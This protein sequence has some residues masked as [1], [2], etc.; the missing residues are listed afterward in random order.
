[1]EFTQTFKDIGR[2]F[3]RQKITIIKKRALPQFCEKSLIETRPFGTDY[4]LAG[5]KANYLFLL[6]KSAGFLPVIL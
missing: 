3:Y 6:S 5:N 4:G 2:Y 1:M